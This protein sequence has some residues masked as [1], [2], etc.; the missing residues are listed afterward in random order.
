MSEG[1]L[2]EEATGV[3]QVQLV[4]DPVETPLRR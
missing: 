3:H 4:G 1:N 2:W